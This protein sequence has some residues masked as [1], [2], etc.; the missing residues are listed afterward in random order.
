MCGLCEAMATHA[1]SH[2]ET[3]WLD[4]ASGT[5]AF[6]GAAGALTGVSGTG[7]ALIDGVLSTRAWS[8]G[9]VTYGFPDA[10][11]DYQS[12]ISEGAGAYAVSAAM[13]T[14]ARGALEADFGTAKDDALSIEG[15]TNLDL[16]EAEGDA[17]QVRI[18]LT[19]SD[20]Y[21]FRTA[22]AYYPSSGASG[23]DVFFYDGVYNYTAPVAGNYAW[24]TMLHELGHAMG[25]SHGHDTGFNGALPYDQDSVE[26]SIMTYRSHVG[27]NASGYRY[28]TWGAPQTFMMADIAALQTLYGA[29]YTTNAGNTVYRWSPGSGETVIDGTVVIAPGANKIFATIWDGGGTDTYDLSAYDDGVEV[30]LAPGGHSVFSDAQLARLGGGPN[31]GYARGNVFNALLHEGNTA[32]LIEN[33]TGGDGS[34]FLSGNSVGN[35]LKGRHGDDT[36]I[37]RGGR[38]TLE[39]GNGNDALQGGADADRLRGGRNDDTLDGGDGDDHLHGQ[40]GN[41][42][43]RGGVG[44]DKVL[45]GSGN[46]RLEG[47]AG[48]D[49][50]NGHRGADTILGGDGADK[51]RGGDG[52]D[53]LTGGTGADIYQFRKLSEGKPTDATRI[54]DFETGR[55]RVELKRLDVDAA[56]GGRQ[57]FDYVEAADFGAIG[58][59]RFE[60][61]GIDGWL[62]GTTSAA[63][64]VDF[65]IRL[66]GVTAFDQ[67]DLIL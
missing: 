2:C 8:G 32:S 6:A 48:N 17:A 63:L 25:L 15:L 26:F 24:H 47:S 59:L 50:L 13:E 33:A 61:D 18:A 58:Q 14:A 52:V 53:L 64:D 21:N 22:W 39:G 12:Y 55:D 56:T 46:D 7:E 10:S 16:V 1:G 62:L 28:E 42:L 67:G 36:L 27:A 49:F 4:A 40:N 19:S 38:D 65:A 29:D 41:D 66:D 57:T 43:V 30:D 34:D 51:I 31:G 20:P 37:G 23:G 5:D 35:V 45:G 9:P 44:K 3:A 54:T 11:D 60:T